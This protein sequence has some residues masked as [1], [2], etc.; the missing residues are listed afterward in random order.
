[1]DRL[2]SDSRV[3]FFARHHRFRLWLDAFLKGRPMSHEFLEEMWIVVALSR[4]SPMREIVKLPKLL[5]RWKIW[6]MNLRAC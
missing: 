2:T 4:L 6:W 3:R 1:M 5:D